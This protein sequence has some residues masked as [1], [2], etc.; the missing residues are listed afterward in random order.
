MMNYESCLCDP[1]KALVSLEIRGAGVIVTYKCPG[2]A[3]EIY[4]TNY[5]VDDIIEDLNRLR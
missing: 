1:D 5:T 2:C 4:D 3:N